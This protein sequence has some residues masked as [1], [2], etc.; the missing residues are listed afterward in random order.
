MS[1]NVSRQL[2]NQVL[3]GSKQKATFR[4]PNTKEL[5]VWVIIA[6]DKLDMIKNQVKD[7]A[8]NQIAKR[9]QVGAELKAADALKRLDAAID[10]EM[11][12]QGGAAPAAK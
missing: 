3:T 1:E 6:E 7:E 2:T 10:T 9:A 5:F 11:A 8:R 12:R 4:D